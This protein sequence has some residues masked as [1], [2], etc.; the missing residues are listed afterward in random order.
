[1][2]A[3]LSPRK[4]QQQVSPKPQPNHSQDVSTELNQNLT[5][6]V[7][8]VTDFQGQV[9]LH[10]DKSI[11]PSLDVR[12]E[13]KGDDFHLHVPHLAKQDDRLR[14]IIER[15]PTAI[16]WMYCAGPDVAKVKFHLSDG[17]N[18]SLA[19]CSFS[20]CD[21]T[22]LLIPDFYFFRDRGYQ[23][24]RDWLAESTENSVPWNE[25]SSEII[26]RGRPTGAGL[27]TVD[28]LQR[29]N[30][31]V[32]QRLRMAMHAKTTPLDF[33]FVNA[34]TP[35]EERII[36]DAG[37]KADR[38]GTK[39]WARRKFA[40]DIDGFATTWDNL[41]HRFLMGNC[42]LK[43]DSQMGFRQWYYH[44][45]RA[46]EHYVPIKRDLSNLQDQ[47]DWVLNNDDNARE[48]AR[49]GQAIAESLTW[50]VVAAETGRSLRNL[51]GLPT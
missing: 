32:R 17:Q 38:I 14:L 22:K 35:L 6:K 49:A 29:D 18:P 9:F 16:G 50:D 40:I 37:F 8:R 19:Q 41:F 51:V 45:L 27:F 21:P 28:P 7:K 15:A 13:R 5:G 2:K 3:L 25:R 47:I 42:V 10:T 34:M 33:R 31:L 44:Q 4:A 23:E 30:P 11:I 26:W 20:S 1:V 36:Q 39:T 43:V 48:I 46:Y 12:V 24:L